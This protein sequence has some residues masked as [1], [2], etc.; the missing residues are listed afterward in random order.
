MMIALATTCLSQK[1]S[2]DSDKAAATRVLIHLRAVRDCWSD[3]Y[4]VI[5]GDDPNLE[6]E[7]LYLRCGSDYRLLF[8]DLQESVSNGVRWITH[9]ELR[10]EMVAANK[11]LIDLDS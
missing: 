9:A 8:D 5:V 11:V 1:S 7:T 3:P 6:N 2:I 10:T 4:M